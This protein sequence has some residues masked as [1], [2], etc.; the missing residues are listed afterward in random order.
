MRRPHRPQDDAL[1]QGGP[2]A[3]RAAVI[4]GPE[5]PV[6]IQSLLDQQFPF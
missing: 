2:L 3:D 5:G 4:F 6:V 1:H